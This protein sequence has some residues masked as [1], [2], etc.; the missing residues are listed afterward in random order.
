M[1]QYDRMSRDQLIDALVDHD[2]TLSEIYNIIH[3]P[4]TTMAPGEKLFWLASRNVLAGERPNADGLVRLPIDDISTFNGMS[5]S[6]NARYANNLVDRFGAKK[7]TVPYVTLKGQKRDLTYVD[8]SEQVWHTPWDIDLPEEKERTINGNGKRCP[9]CETYNLQVKTV[10]IMY[11][12]VQECE[13]CGYT[14]ISPI[15][16]D[17]EPLEPGEYIPDKKGPQPE[18]L[19]SDEEKSSEI[20]NAHSVD[21]RMN[22]AQE[23]QQLPQWVV[24]RYGKQPRKG[25][26]LDKVPYDVNRYETNS[27]A[28][29]SDPATW[30]TYQEAQELYERAKRN[31]WGNPYAGVG[32]VFK[33]GGGIVGIDYDNTTDIRIHSYSEISVSGNGVHTFARG[34]IPA[35]KRK[36][37]IEIYDHGR[38]FTWTGNHLAGTPETIEDCQAEIDALYQELAPVPTINVAPVQQFTCSRSDAEILELARNARNGSG[39]KFRA[40]YDDGNT[41]GYHSHSEADLALCA[42]LAFWCDGCVST[43]ERLFWQSGLKS[44]KWERADYRE[45]TINKALELWQLRKAS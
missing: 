29:V 24:W 43:I 35:G 3:L 33:E 42:L 41:T 19:F 23:L 22:A 18:D 9:I 5:E 7:E 27:R 45:R 32:F 20:C 25:G 10:R 39:A 15:L 8:R 13:C 31:R 14:K 44:E 1:T 36:N 17:K 40:L 6:S 16:N 12:E 11:Q 26:K 21:T 37:G 4:N 2:A 30:S 34:S 38:F 28:S